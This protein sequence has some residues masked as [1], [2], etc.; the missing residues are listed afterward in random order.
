MGKKT[1][2]VTG[3]STGIG[4]ATALRL[5]EAGYDVWAGA[6]RVE[7]MTDL[8]ERG[9]QALPLDVCDDASMVAFVDEVLAAS[10]GH[11]GVLVNNAGYGSYGAVEQVPMEEARRQMDVNVFGLARMVQLVLPGMREAGYGRVVNVSSMGGIIWTPLGAWY[12]ASKFAVEGF[13][14]CL[15]LETEPFGI[16]TILIEPGGVA[17]EWAG[18]SADNL[19]ARSAEGPYADIAAGYVKT[20]REQYEGDNLSQP[21]EIADL[22]LK[23]VSADKPKTRYLYGYMS[24]TMVRMRR[25]LGDRGYDNLMRRFCK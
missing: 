25:I 18:I 14:D 1:A 23:A 24:G 20:M 10:G 2:I 16:A 19:L 13:S 3:A 9:V 8:A 21:G 5:S 11:V 12:H 17:S 22:I 4:H 6:R 7:K 15:R